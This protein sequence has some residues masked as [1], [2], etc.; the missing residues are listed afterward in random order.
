[1]EISTYSADSVTYSIAILS[2]AYLL[3]LRK[4]TTPISTK[5]IFCI[6]LIA[7]ALGLLKYVYGTILLLY[8][9][10]PAERF[11][12]KRKFYLYGLFFIVIFFV[13]VLLW[14]IFAKA[15]QTVELAAL[16]EADMH[17]QLAF[18][19]SEPLQFVKIFFYTLKIHFLEY[20]NQFVGV[21]GWIIEVIPDWFFIFYGVVLIFAAAVGN[22]NLTF[23]Q[24]LFI[25][26][27]VIPTVFAMFFYTYVLWTPVKHEDIICIYG[28]YFIPCALMLFAAFSFVK[29]FKYE[30]FFAFIFGNICAGVT[31]RQIFDYFY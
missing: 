16:P 31:I 6:G 10:I 19:I 1:M 8:F 18:I 4:S 27:A 28:R 12:N 17:A 14:I 13:T 24:R 22:V 21:I 15:G 11:E 9:L 5:E 26:A 7:V 30:T 29:N 3:H 25:I 20:Y 23:Q 2:T